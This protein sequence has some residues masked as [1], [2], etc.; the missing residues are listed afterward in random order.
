MYL[1]NYNL[2]YYKKEFDQDRRTWWGGLADG[3]RNR[4]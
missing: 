2:G 3:K 4:L 1:A